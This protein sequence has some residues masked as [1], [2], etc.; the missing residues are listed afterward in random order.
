MYSL[1]KWFYRPKK[2]DNSILARFFWADEE[3]NQVATELDSFDGRKEPERCSALVNQLRACQDKVLNIC[4]D[5]M[6]EAIPHLRANRD[7]RSK[8][9]DEVLQE[10]L[11]GQLW[12]GAECLA[13]GSNIL[14]REIESA[15]IRPLAKAVTCSLD[16]IRCLLR[17]QCL[18]NTPGYPERVTE[19]LRTFDRLYAEFEL[20]Y[21]S[22][23]VPVK[24]AKEYHL[25]QEVTVLFSET[26]QRALRIGLI[27]QDLVDDCDPSL[28]FTIPR[29]AITCGL[30]IYPD[31]PLNVDGDPSEMSELFK[32]FYTLLYKIR[33]LLCTLSKAEL[34]L[35][36]RT[37]CSLD[38]PD[39]ILS[40]DQSHNEEGFFVLSESYFGKTYENCKQFI[41]DFYLFN[42]GQL[43]T[44]ISEQQNIS[45]EEP[46]S[47]IPHDSSPRATS[48]TTSSFK[49]L[50]S[51]RHNVIL[52]TDEMSQDED[53]FQ[54]GDDGF[55]LGVN[56]TENNVF[57]EN[58]RR[59]GSGSLKESF[60]DTHQND[61]CVCEDQIIDKHE[62]GACAV[63]NDE[64]DFDNNNNN[65]SAH[66]TGY[67][68]SQVL[69]HLDIPELPSVLEESNTV[70]GSSS[71]SLPNDVYVQN[72]SAK[73]SFHQSAGHNRFACHSLHHQKSNV[74]QAMCTSLSEPGTIPACSFKHSPNNA[75]SYSQCNCDNQDNSDYKRSAPLVISKVC[76]LQQETVGPLPS[77]CSSC[78]IGHSI[79]SVSSSDWE[80]SSTGTNSHHSAGQ[81]DE[82]ISLALQ[83]QEIA[84]HNQTRA[85]FKNSTKLIHRLFVCISGV[86]DQ[87]QTNYASDLRNILKCVFDINCTKTT[88]E[89]SNSKC[90]NLQ[91]NSN[92]SE[93]CEVNSSNNEIT[94]VNI[95]NERDILVDHEEIVAQN[96][97]RCLNSDNY[98]ISVPETQ[99][100]VDRAEEVVPEHLIIESRYTGQ[101][102][103]RFQS[104][105]Q[106]PT[107]NCEGPPMWLPDFITE[108][109]MACLATFTLIRRRHH[110]RNCGKI[111][112]SRC[113][114]NFVPLPQYGITKPVRV[115][116]GCFVYQV[117]GL[118]VQQQ[119]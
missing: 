65:V 63:E 13:A 12:F 35:L 5:I 22:A 48:S 96:L 24:T 110:C 68:I 33:E 107:P 60:D 100:N 94:A 105:F 3:L 71:I 56:V 14:N 79:T 28:M 69:S 88:P 16:S 103:T 85:H 4:H 83:E 34:H 6:D 62:N 8:F 53:V 17:E 98:S 117:T 57:R 81:D 2:E 20:S 1:R 109:C 38:D 52:I 92:L 108:H 23:M 61:F 95:E 70:P 45:A 46:V 39:C 115:C 32:P 18:R 118:V 10:N 72:R 112:C 44:E 86:A 67:H 9:P 64:L 37:L 99:D 101:L 82:E 74:R 51:S 91:H 30:L 31:G 90:D 40:S 104:H 66:Q 7:F 106:Q 15:S 27:N 41:R 73:D 114:A 102:G 11:A 25:Q 116:N 42:F 87:L 47:C 43:P 21:V 75:I 78:S 119:V 36:E 19:A 80:T 29:L 49:S 55:S 93:S 77:S 111:F 26:L 84:F 97:N 89:S 59:Q 50:S 76:K 54:N 58:Y 113:S